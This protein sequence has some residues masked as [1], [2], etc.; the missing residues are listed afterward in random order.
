[1]TA[2]PP[3]FLFVRSVPFLLCPPFDKC[4]VMKGCCEIGILFKMESD[5]RE[6]FSLS[7]VCDQMREREK[8][9]VLGGLKWGCHIV[10]GE[11][12]GGGSLQAPD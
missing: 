1:M 10:R 8:E 2:F 7:A 5:H 4:V 3:R 11:A 9:A 6:A 12:G